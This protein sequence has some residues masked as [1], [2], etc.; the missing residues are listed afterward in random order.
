MISCPICDERD[1]DED[2]TL[3]AK[4]KSGAWLQVCLNC[5]DDLMAGDAETYKSFW[6]FARDR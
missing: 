3:I 6:I 2:D 5:Y 4:T 1:L